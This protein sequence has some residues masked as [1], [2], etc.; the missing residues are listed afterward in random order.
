MSRIRPLSD[1]S[2]A[3]RGLVRAPGFA[4]IAILSLALGI[5]ANTAMFSVAEAALWRP[6]PVTEPSRLVHLWETNPLKRWTDAP[7]SPANFADW[8]QRNHVFSAMGA[9]LSAGDKSGGGF[10]VVMTG[11]GEPQRL[12]AVMRTGNLFQILGVNPLLGRTFRDQET[13]ESDTHVVILS[14]QL[15]QGRFGGDPNIVGHTVELNA[16]LYDVIGVM[17]RDFYFPSRRVQVWTALGF[18]PAVFVEQRR[19]H[20]WDVV[21][22]LKPGVTMAQAQAEMTAI[23]SAI[24]A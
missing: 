17:P 2:L 13:F 23:A 6:M 4:I 10:D 20:Y 21:A 12:K 15:W 9:Y 19:P 24:G 1:L 7:A 8:Q 5:G 11:S 18:E 3:F 14:W 16:R 22:R